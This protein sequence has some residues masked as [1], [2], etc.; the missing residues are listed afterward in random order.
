M[1]FKNNWF[2]FSKSYLLLAS[3][4]CLELKEDFENEDKNKILII[5]ILFNFKHALE[6]ILK[7]ISFEIY[8]SYKH[9]HDVI[10]L[11]SFIKKEIPNLK[12]NLRFQQF[13][14]YM[15]DVTNKGYEYKIYFNFS[16]V[17]KIVLKVNRIINDYYFLH[18]FEEFLLSN[19]IKDKNNVIF[20]FPEYSKLVDY[21]KLITTIDNHLIDEIFLD[22][23]YILKHLHL[24]YIMLE[25]YNLYINKV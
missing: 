2:I 22:I 21:E 20:R 4:W 5:S 9:T 23:D 18:K 24:F 15:D 1:L 6:L 14:K 16:D 10:K 17:E 11:I 19:E 3:N 12:N 13:L 7:A 25:S 8:W